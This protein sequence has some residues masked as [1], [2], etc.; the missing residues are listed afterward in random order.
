MDVPQPT[1]PAGF[2]AGRQGEGQPTV[3]VVMMTMGNRP[4]DLRKALDSLLAQRGVDLDVVLL[5]NG[6]NPDENPW[7]FPERVRPIYSQENLGIPQGRNVAAAQARGDYLFF[8]D[9]DA[10]LPNDHVL[11]DM[12]TEMEKDPKNAV[13]GPLGQDPTGKPTPRRWIPRLRVKDGGRPGPATWFLEGIHMSRRT[14]FEQVGGWPGHFFYGHEGI[15]LAWRLIDAGWT[16]QYVPSINVYH[17]ATAPSRHAVYYRMNARNR[18]W[19]AKRNLPAPL[20]VVYVLDWVAITLLRVKDKESLKVWFRGLKEGL[21]SDAG[22][23]RP[24]S[25]RTVATLTKLGRP[26]IL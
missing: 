10:T 19:V 16:I 11:L 5:G 1:A 24:M 20:A 22:Q 6:W 21:T 25:W 3:G 26:P 4:D 12:V 2:D 15:D 7:P 13:V 9:D 17:P 23:R 14:A 8:Y 18:V